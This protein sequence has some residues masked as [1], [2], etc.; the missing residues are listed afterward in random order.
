M[1]GSLPR[2]FTEGSPE[3][4]TPPGGIPLGIAGC[5]EVWLGVGDGYIWLSDHKSK[6][7]WSMLRPQA[8]ALGALLAAAIKTTSSWP[9][10]FAAPVAENPEVRNGEEG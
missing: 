5:F 1:P 7:W 10:P 6:K 4:F 9:S 3:G 8:A 2:K